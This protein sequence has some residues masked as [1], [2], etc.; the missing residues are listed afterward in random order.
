MTTDSDFS[1]PLIHEG[2]SEH[3]WPKD[4]GRS[5]RSDCDSCVVIIW[6]G[7]VRVGR[8]S[9]FRKY[10]PT[11]KETVEKKEKFDSSTPV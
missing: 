1:A 6:F 3:V 2:F 7:T 4:F 11:S 10:G 5:F 8:R 9:T